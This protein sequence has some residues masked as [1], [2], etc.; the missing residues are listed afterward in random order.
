MPY[1]DKTGIIE[2][3]LHV[4]QSL[5]DK[6]ALLAVLAAA[7]E[8]IQ[9]DMALDGIRALI[10]ESKA[11]PWLV[12]DQNWWEWEGWLELLPFSDRPAAT[13]DAL[14]LIEPSRRHPWQLRRLLSALGYAPTAEADEILT[15]LQKKDA[16]FFNEH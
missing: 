8:I 2:T 14:E 4:Q 10:G 15:L 5:R 3:L 9:A 1:G 6:Q 13:L 12:G 16:R 11:K 7:G